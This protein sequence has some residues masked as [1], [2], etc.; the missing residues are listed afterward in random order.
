MRWPPWAAAQPGGAASRRAA[1][2]QQAAAEEQC[3][4]QRGADLVDEAGVDAGQSPGQRE[5][6]ATGTQCH[7]FTQAACISGAL[8]SPFFEHTRALLQLEKL[9]ARLRLHAAFQ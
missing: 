3:L 9:E 7:Q 8:G 1:G 5:A 6:C 4:A 2:T